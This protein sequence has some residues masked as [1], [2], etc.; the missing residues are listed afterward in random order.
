MI[1]A[2][3]SEADEQYPLYLDPQDFGQP[4]PDLDYSIGEEE[5][6]QYSLYTPAQPSYESTL[7]D[8]NTMS[9]KQLEGP[10][11]AGA[12]QSS[13][14]GPSSGSGISTSVQNAINATIATIPQG[15]NDYKL[16]DQAEFSKC[17]ENVESFLLEC[18][19]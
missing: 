10:S 9:N 19:S 2:Q 15:M 12:G 6:E 7:T 16:S 3:L 11:N 18:T 13:S 8:P 14:S 5:E 4:L 17:A 1:Q